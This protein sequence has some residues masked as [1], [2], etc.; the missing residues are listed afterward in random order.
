MP[1]KL[2]HGTS[3]YKSHG[4]IIGG[5]YGDE[6]PCRRFWRVRPDS[7]DHVGFQHVSTHDVD[8]NRKDRAADRAC[9]S[10]SD[11]YIL[12]GVCGTNSVVECDLAKV[13]VAGSNPVSRFQ[14]SESSAAFLPHL[15][16]KLR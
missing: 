5:I 7:Y 13:E 3:V 8:I 6:S 14:L 4:L 11:S 9:L 12:R 16:N 1:I 2:L 10:D 15:V